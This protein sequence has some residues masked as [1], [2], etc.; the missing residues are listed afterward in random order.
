MSTTYSDRNLLFGILAL[1]MDFLCRDAL[2]DAMH[3]WI[4]DKSKPLGDILV[5]QQ[6]MRPDE[7]DALNLL[8]QKHIDHHGGDVEKSLA[9]MNVPTQLREELSSLADPD[10]QASIDRLVAPS[11]SDRPRPLPT[12]VSVAKPADGQRYQILR[13]HDKGGIGEVFV[14]LDQELNRQVALKEIQQH[15]ATDPHS[16]GRFVREAE[17]TGGLEHPGI[18]PVYGLGQYADGRPFY[19]MRFIQGETLKDAIARYHQTNA[20]GSGA[21]SPEFEL[22]AL[23][24]RFVAVC[25]TIAYAHSRGVIHRDI[26]P[27]NI[28]LGKYGET[29][30]V[31][32]GM[33]KSGTYGP[34]RSATEDLPEPMLVPS[35]ADAI[36]TQA[37]AAMGTPSYMSPEQA[38]GRLD[39]LGAASDIYSLG[40]TLYTLLTGHPP[41]EGKKTAEVLRKAQRGEW[42]PPRQVKS[43]VP[44]GLEAVCRKA[45]APLPSARYSTALALAADVERWLADEPVSA[46]R[47]PFRLRAGRWMR[48]HQTLMT[49]AATGLLVMTLAV[50]SGTW[51]LD[52]QRTE[53]RRGVESALEEVARLQE[54]GRWSEA[55][56]VL[57]QA[58][59][60]LGQAGPHDLRERLDQGARNLDLVARLDAIRLRRATWIEDDFDNEGADRDYEEAFRAS[61]RIEVHGDEAAA[62]AWVRGSAVRDALLAALD[63]WASCAQDRQRRNWVLAVARAAD[64]D[65]WRK[66]ARDAAVWE[67]KA[68]LVRLMKEGNLAEQSP[69]LLAALG[70][71]LRAL[72][73]DAEPLLRATWQ[74][75]PEDFWINFWLGVVLKDRLQSADAI[76]HYLAALAVRP[77]TPAVHNNLGIVLHVIGRHEEAIKEYRKAL[78]LDPKLALAHNNL[79]STLK[80]LRRYEEAVREYRKAIELDPKFAVAYS[81][82]GVALQE[83][84][85]S[86][87]ALAACHRAIELDP[88]D[89]RSY[90]G[91]GIVL[92]GIGRREEALTALRKAIQLKPMFA[93]AHNNLG[94]VLLGMGKREEAIAAFRQAIK[95]NSRDAKAHYNLGVVLYDMGRRGEALA[96]FRKSIE[97]GPRN[98]APHTGL[99]DVL[100]AL[101]LKEEADAEYRQALELDP[102]DAKIH[103]DLGN[104]LRDMGRR[105][106]A[107]AAFCKSIELDPKYP[108]AHYNLASILSNMG[109]RE[110]AV[111]EFRKTIELDP[112]FAP[113]HNNLGRTLYNSGRREE[114]VEAF[115]RAIQ[116][117]PKQI[118]A[119]SNLGA[120]LS[121]MGQHE[122][123][124]LAY[125]KAIELDPKNAKTHTN[126][127]ITLSRM[128]RCEEA[129]G[130]YRRAIEIDPKGSS[131]HYHLG[132]AL[133][134][135]GRPEEAVSAFREAIRLKPKYAEAHC[136][137]GLVLRQLGRFD[138]SLTHLRQGHQLGSKQPGWSYPSDQWLQA[139]ERLVALDAK[140]LAILKGDAKAADAAEQIE[141]ALLCQTK[142]RYA[143]AARFFGDAFT[144]QPKLADDLV[145]DHRYKAACCAVLA[146]AGQRDAVKL[147][148]KERA[149]LRKQALD[150]LQADLISWTKQIDKGNEQ[151]RALAQKTL[152]HWQ[153]DANLAGLRDAAALDKLPE[154]E[155]DACRTLWNDV[156]ALL[157]R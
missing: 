128:G 147:D 144:A 140:L 111:A 93:K 107:V 156:A 89:A 20:D 37:G 41:I 1:Q 56:A 68:A 7:R 149:R 116:L 62:A 81:N 105:E 96:A 136:N 110:E 79:G 90:D 102:T 121:V 11:E 27:S 51:W 137:L 83:M 97:F 145:T 103:Y 59:E 72:G 24:T 151:E 52:R 139:A 154:A 69:Q 100:S 40:A 55:R 92:S 19:A 124:V 94:A 31:D 142:K 46:W 49:A 101:G 130:A 2:I 119:Y 42:L 54:Q 38:S 104:V 26:K 77:G 123:A 118:Q 14:A 5:E 143:A 57:G 23:L 3:A 10:V 32:W 44:P 122:E 157:K 58:R 71:Q 114:A 48:R 131:A 50:G 47:E 17:I 88:K 60:R 34:T 82:L 18:V 125:R 138:E 64:A 36:E 98:A 25:N 135:T 75:H 61:G 65:P 30:V 148:E 99:G 12:T 146:A 115:R 35:L 9:A 21:C 66:Q 95:V 15:H 39:L 6:A 153:Q 84:G 76:G 28:M 43:N 33:A 85:R 70:L 106:E 73:A 108:Q 152:R 150:W 80:D 87:E 45:M 74:R 133:R 120:V 129:M 91:L 53:Q 78:E 126:L 117:D 109:R 67:N 112:K 13:P 63:D 113:A 22:R 132:N 4:L 29:L 141:L 8:V 127:G 16:R 86:E 134:D 155:R